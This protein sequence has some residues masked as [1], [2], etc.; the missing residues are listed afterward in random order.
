MEKGRLKSSDVVRAV[1]R[2]GLDWLFQKLFEHYSVEAEYIKPGKK[3]IKS[4]VIRVERL[5]KPK[6]AFKCHSWMYQTSFIIMG[7]NYKIQEAEDWPAPRGDKIVIRGRTFEVIESFTFASWLWG[8]CQ[9]V[10]MRIFVKEI[11]EN[12]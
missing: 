12:N 8:E 10:G 11:T 5:K 4:R 6:G 9:R 1:R 2:R 3:P 7:E